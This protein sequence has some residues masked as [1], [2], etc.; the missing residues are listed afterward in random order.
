MICDRIENLAKYDAYAPYIARICDYLSKNDAA[1]LTVGR[2]DIC[3]DIFVNVEG[4][5]PGENALFEAH[6]DY[7]DLQYLVAGDE[8]IACAPI[9]DCVLEKEYDGAID[10]G[11]YKVVPDGAEIRI[12]M[13][14]GVFA[15]FEPR[16]PHSPGRK[17][18]ADHVKKLI[19]KI[20]VK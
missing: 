5:A 18:K 9:S 1:L 8:E 16:D 14:A 2:H 4:Y 17:Y 10:A 13:K 3:E 7:I 20:K 11:F 19:F 6:R 12:F 15:I